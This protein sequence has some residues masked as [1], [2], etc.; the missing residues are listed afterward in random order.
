[1][2]YVYCLLFT[3]L[4]SLSNLEFGVF[5]HSE[6]HIIVYL[7]ACWLLYIHYDAFFC[8]TALS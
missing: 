3:T 5:R 6:L 1:M 8:F 4:V 7:I 2:P